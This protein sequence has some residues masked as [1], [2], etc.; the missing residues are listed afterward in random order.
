MSLNNPNKKQDAQDSNRQQLKQELVNFLEKA[1][2]RVPENAWKR[3]NDALGAIATAVS[4]R[5][6]LETPLKTFA[7]IVG[8]P[9]FNGDEE[10]LEAG[11]RI[12]RLAQGAR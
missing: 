7:N 3:A 4:Q 6:S 8:H 2:G 9:P 12:G 1:R 5:E 11:E 10:L